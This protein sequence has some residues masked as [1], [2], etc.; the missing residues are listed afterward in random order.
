MKQLA[1]TLLI[2]LFFAALCGVGIGLVA[3]S[4]EAGILL[5]ACIWLCTFHPSWMKSDKASDTQEKRSEV[6]NVDAEPGPISTIVIIVLALGLGGLLVPLLLRLGLP[7]RLSF[8]LP[9]LGCFLVIAWALLR[10]QRG[11]RGVK[12]SQDNKTK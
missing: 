4:L 12:S 6:Q 9:F 3:W 2:N 8:R 1:V 5:G 7:Y 11:R 10:L